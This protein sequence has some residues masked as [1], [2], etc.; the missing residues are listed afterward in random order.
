[1]WRSPT[2]PKLHL[3]LDHAIQV[4]YRIIETWGNREFDGDQRFERLIAAHPSSGPPC[5][6]P[7]QQDAAWEEGG[8]PVW[9]NA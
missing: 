8:W 3:E 1:M 9:V 5:V 4:P 6:L 2:N 7:E